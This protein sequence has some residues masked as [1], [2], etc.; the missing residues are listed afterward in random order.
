MIAQAKVSA[1]LSVS[2]LRLDAAGAAAK[3]R[4]L[5]IHLAAAFLRVVEQYRMAF[6]NIDRTAI[7]A[8]VGALQDASPPTLTLV[9]E[10]AGFAR[11]TARRKV[12]RLIADRVLRRNRDGRIE[13]DRAATERPAL[14]DAVR[15]HNAEVARLINVLIDLDVVGNEGPAA[16]AAATGPGGPRLQPAEAISPVA[17]WSLMLEL[18]T[19]LHRVF[20]T[21]RRTVGALDEVLIQLAVVVI[22][23]E[24]LARDGLEEELFDLKRQ[25]PRDRLHFC[26]VS[27]LAAASGLPV[28]TTRRKTLDLVV[29]G[30]LQRDASGD[31]QFAPGIL[32]QPKFNQL[33]LD[34]VV[35]LTG[36][37]NRLL[38]LGTLARAPA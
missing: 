32:Q 21:Y 5:A 25:L 8:A 17:L 16:G 18:F 19:T 22:I 14:A 12:Q 3:G 23:A 38:Q 29:Q 7:V 15:R 33:V 2:A 35:Q 30:R 27:S 4:P 20:S 13:V 28:E 24:H 36:L 10:A 31:V 6:G 26:N 37:A 34:H 1:S 11:E 9:A